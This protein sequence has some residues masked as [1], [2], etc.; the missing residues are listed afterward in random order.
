MGRS[1]KR[2]NKQIKNSPN[3]PESLSKIK[4][5]LTMTSKDFDSAEQSDASEHSSEGIPES[6]HEGTVCAKIEDFYLL[7]N[8][9][10]SY[11]LMNESQKEVIL[12]NIEINCKRAQYSSKIASRMFEEV[13]KNSLLKVTAA[14][15]PNDILPSGYSCALYDVRISSRGPDEKTYRQNKW[16]RD[17]VTRGLNFMQLTGKEKKFDFAIYANKKFTGGV[18]DEDDYQPESNDIWEEFCLDSP[19]NATEVI[20]MTK[21]NGEAGHF[22]VRKIGGEYF[23]IAGSKNVH[24]LFKTYSDIE[25]YTESRFMVAK[26]VAEA[27]LDAFNEMEESKLNILKHF[28]STTKTTI[29]GELLQPHYQHIVDLSH[30]KKS[31]I[32]GLMLTSLPGKED[33]D[34]LTTIPP[35]TCLEF[36]KF[37]GIS[38]PEYYSISTEDVKENILLWRYYSYL[39]CI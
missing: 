29:V 35:Q 21:L 9:L 20:C 26:T 1:K 11:Q 6:L 10:D 5:S 31:T 30:L 32:Y 7:K 3:T 36:F 16:I 4:G 8:S 18:G 12:K 13:K 37:F 28:L 14:A 24:M 34:S 22:T 39:R 33:D 23:I 38:I 27:V 19:V 25:K 17:N 2:Q 15:V